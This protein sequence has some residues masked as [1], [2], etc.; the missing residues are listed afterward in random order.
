MVLE[1]ELRVNCSQDRWSSTGNQE[2]YLSA[3]DGS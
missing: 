1:K 3:L 2:E